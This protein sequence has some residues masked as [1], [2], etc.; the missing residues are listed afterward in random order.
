MASKPLVPVTLSGRELH[1][2]AL[3]RPELVAAIVP[4]GNM[5]SR[6]VLAGGYELEVKGTPSELAAS[7]VAAAE[8][9]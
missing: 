7:F 5:S 1:S 9:K 3:V 6:L 8:G 4:T 2:T